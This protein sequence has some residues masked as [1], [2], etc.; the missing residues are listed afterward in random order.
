[1]LADELPEDHLGRFAAER[2]RRPA[3]VPTVLSADEA[4]RIIEAIKPQSMHRL[5]VELLYGTGLRVMEC[6][7]LRVRDLDFDRDQIIVRAGKGDKDR[8]VM[9]PRSLCRR[10]VDQIHR[11]RVQHARDMKKDGGYVPVPDSIAHKVRYAEHDWRWQFVFPSVTLRRDEQG[12]GFRW[13][14]HPGVLDRTIKNAT[15]RAD[16]AKRVS[17]HTLRHSFAT[18]LLEAGYDVRQVQSLLGHANLQTTMIYTHVMNK[19]AVTVTSTLD[20]LDRRPDT[21]TLAGNKATSSA[22]ATLESTVFGA[23]MTVGTKK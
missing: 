4:L 14:A 3:R 10:L 11:V 18:H 21:E 9:M 17:A 1:M 16:V 2:S 12:R 15:R 8:V 7:T 19:P 20:R 5:M 23:E 6:C 22:R 13:F